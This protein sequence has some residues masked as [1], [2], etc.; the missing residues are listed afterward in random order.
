MVI[1]NRSYKSAN[2]KIQFEKKIDIANNYSI[3]T[4]MEIINIIF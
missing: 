4:I 1:F 2:C 3:V